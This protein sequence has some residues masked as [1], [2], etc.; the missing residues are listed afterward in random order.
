MCT[1]AAPMATKSHSL[2]VYN[3]VSML[4]LL[5]YEA[6]QTKELESFSQGS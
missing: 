1:L 6:L 3:G 2:L 5:L 4:Y